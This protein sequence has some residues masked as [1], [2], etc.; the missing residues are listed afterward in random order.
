MKP[1]DLFL[2]G[3]AIGIYIGGMLVFLTCVKR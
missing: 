3:V 1:L 2:T